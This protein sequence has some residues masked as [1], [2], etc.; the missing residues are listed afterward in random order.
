M[1]MVNLKKVEI[2][3]MNIDDF[4]KIENIIQDEYD[5]FWNS[6][7]LKSELLKSSCK[8]IVAKEADEILGF[9][10]IF[11]TLDDVQIMNIVVKKNKRR[12]GIGNIL[13]KNLI[14]L[15]KQT[16]LEILTLEVNS[17]N[18]PAQNLYKKFGFEVIGI[19]KRY[20]NNKDD[21]IIMNFNLKK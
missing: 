7:I 19:R 6:N 4:N 17:N 8:Y 21:A 13:L 3:E 9:A 11:V 1:N 5:E 2:S 12:M 15:A 10:G 16:N 20:Y 18:I 14:N